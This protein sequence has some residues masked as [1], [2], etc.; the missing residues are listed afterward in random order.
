MVELTLSETLYEAGA[1][2]R[3]V[4][5]PVRGFVSLV[6]LVDDAS[7]LEV[8]MV[9]AEGMLGVHLALGVKTSPLRSIVQGPGDAWRMS[10]ARFRSEL[11]SNAALRDG[12]GRYVAVLMAQLSSSAACA[13]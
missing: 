11:S 10:A 12:I 6:A 3:Q 13:R 7:A 4:Y 2:T 1:P 5:F 9:G 8:G